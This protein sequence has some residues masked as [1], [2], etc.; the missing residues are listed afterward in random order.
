MAILSIQQKFDKEIPSV[1]G[2]A[3]YI[4]ERE[5]LITIDKII[6][7]SGLEKI[8]IDYFFD[9]ARKNKATEA[10]G[11]GKPVRLTE[12]EIE[13]TYENAILALRASILRKQLTQVPQ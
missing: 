4:A 6:H 1:F 12:D 10:A 5:L 7:Q 11:T 13:R 9:N 2:N 3:E 8:V